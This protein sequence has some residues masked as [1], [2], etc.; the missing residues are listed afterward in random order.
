MSR[1]A[2]IFC[3]VFG[4]V[5][6]FVGGMG[7]PLVLMNPGGAAP[8]AATAFAALA[9]VGAVFLAATLFLLRQPKHGGQGALAGEE[10]VGRYLANKPEP[11][12]WNGVRYEVQYLLPKP[13]KN[14]KPSSLHV[15]VPVATPTTLH[16]SRESV[17]DRVCK[18]VGIARECQSGDREFDTAVYVRCPSEAYAEA[19]LADAD[20]RAA[21][22]A[23]RK[24][25]YR[26]VQLTGTQAV[27]HWPGF[28]PN[29]HDHPEL[30]AATADLLALLAKDLPA[31][32][33]DHA[34]AR[35]DVRRVW[36][37]GLWLFA[38]LYAVTLIAA[39][40]YPTIHTWPLVMSAVPLFVGGYVAFG[41]VSAY[42]LSGTSTAHDRW[43]P[44]MVTG[45]LCHGLGSI[46]TVAAVN[47]LADPGPLV[48]RVL[49]IVDK[50]SQTSSGKNR[51]T[52][53]YVTVP[54]W[55]PGYDTTEFTVSGGDYAS[56]TPGRSKLQLVTGTGRL[57][58]EWLMSKGVQP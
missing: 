22:L 18:S 33:P 52:T 37:V 58:I 12:E 50:R 17:F 31:D 13:G 35:F 27:A 55:E 30:T 47:A 57:G 14:P 11:C 2:G 32:D 23:L 38:L 15:R 41:W 46:G 29:A 26:D 40:N 42:L 34:P 9:V 3:L 49:P 5:F 51:T 28:D 7:L 56:V 4:I 54:A 20:K 10:R 6:L 25:G 24:L 19:F 53:Y 44:L 45:L 39:F 21:V 8:G 43:Y 1:A 16:F 36:S 48:E